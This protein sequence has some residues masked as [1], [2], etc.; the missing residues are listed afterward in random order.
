MFNGLAFDKKGQYINNVKKVYKQIR[1]Q[2]LLCSH[3]QGTKMGGSV[4]KKRHSNYNTTTEADC[5][6][7]RKQM[8]QE[9]RSNDSS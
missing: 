7:S 8:H 2:L 3:L 5:S 9:T 6:Y 1:T 4:F